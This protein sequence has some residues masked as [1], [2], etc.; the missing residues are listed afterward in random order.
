LVAGGLALAAWPPRQPLTVRPAVQIT[1]S[2]TP[3]SATPSDS[4]QVAGAATAPASTPPAKSRSTPRPLA[5]TPTPDTRP[6]VTVQL[7]IKNAI[8]SFNVA[9][10]SGHTDACTIL[11]EAKA[12]G[13][14]HS[15][16]LIYYPSFQSNYVSELNGYPNNWTFKYNGVLPPVGC[17]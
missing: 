10:T 15:V 13:K 1:A 6:Q 2:T 5:Q 4:P 3:T 8:T 9:L 11:E 14:V 12:E 7:R 17:S 16:T